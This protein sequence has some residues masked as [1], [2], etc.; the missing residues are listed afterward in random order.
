MRQA[1]RYHKHYQA[2]RRKHSFVDL[3]RIPELAAEAARGPV[4]DFDFDLAILFSDLLFPLEALGLSLTYEDSGPKLN[5]H[6]DASQLGKLRSVADAIPH[7]EFQREAVR[8]T[9]EVIPQSKSVIGF[10]GGPWTLYVY[11][12]EG[13]HQGS[14]R[15]SK[16]DPKLYRA[17]AEHLVPLLIENIRLQLDGGAEVVMV[18]DTA[19]GEVAPGWFVREALPDIGRLVSAFPGKIGYYSKGSQPAHLRGPA[20]DALPLA[21]VG[22]DWRWSMEEALSMFGSHGFVQGNFDPAL[23]FLSPDAFADELRR[24]LGPL[25]DLA[26]EQRR[27][28]VCGLGHGLLPATPEENVRAFV[29]I[30]REM[31]A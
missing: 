20:L 17:F 6:L 13:S 25:V 4:E 22:V 12:V 18:L 8:R 7:L 19:A 30:V 23:L 28:W 5:P 9:R 10:V 31:F 21:G 14:L 11:A 15:K 16:S 2:L 26:P 1:G 27:G 24:Y 29:T 3:C